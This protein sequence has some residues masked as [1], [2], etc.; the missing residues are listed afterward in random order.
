MRFI[1]LGHPSGSILL[2]VLLVIASLTLLGVLAI[3]TTAVDMAIAR[4]HRDLRESF[5]LAEAAAM[6][7]LQRML[8][9]PAV[10]LAECHFIW[11]HSATEVEQSHLDFRRPGNWH[12]DDPQHANAL[13]S[14]LDAHTFLAATESRVA[15][16]SSLIATDSRLYVNRLYGLCTKHDADNVVQIG[17]YMRY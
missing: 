10:D 2:V 5:Y 9:S 12:T 1:S 6:E 13:Q 11:H 15:G 7:G 3:N 16:G 14:P 8:N 4:N 17:Y